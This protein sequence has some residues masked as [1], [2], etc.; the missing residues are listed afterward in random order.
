M[1][2]LIYYH[3]FV[4]IHVHHKSKLHV[5]FYLLN[6]LFL[7]INLVKGFISEM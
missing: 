6:F 3:H 7:E 4:V 1:L 5:S 2:I